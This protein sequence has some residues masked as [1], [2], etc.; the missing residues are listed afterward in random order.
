MTRGFQTV[1]TSHSGRCGFTL[2][3]IL[4]VIII[5]A[6]LAAVALPI[7]QGY[8][9][10]SQA[11]EL[12]LKY[13]AIR[14]NIQVAA[15]TGEVQAACANLSDTVQA[16][17]LRSDHAL[18]A[19][20]FEPVAGGFTP[21]LTMCATQAVQGGHGVEVVREAHHI[22]SRNSTISQ[23]AVI[24]ASAVSFSV[25]LAG[26]SALCKA[27]PPGGA[28][29]AGCNPGSGGGG[30]NGNPNK[31][32][33]PASGAAS[34]PITPASGGASSPAATL[35]VVPIQPVTIST[36]ATGSGAVAQAGTAGQNVCPAVTPGQVSRQAMSFASTANGRVSSVGNLNTRGNLP[37]V[38]A[39]VVIA[40]RSANAPGATLLSYTTSRPGSGFSLWNPQ[41]L[42]ITLAG[43]DYNTGFNAD[44]GQDHRITMSWHGASGLLTLFDNGRQVWQ[45]AGVNKF[46]NLG[47]NGQLTIGQDQRPV[48]G[49]LFNFRAGYSGTIVA[50]SLANRAA[51]AAMVSSGPLANVFPAGN[52][53]LTNVVMGSNG[54]PVDTTGH[55]SYRAA[56]GVS[57]ANAMVDTGVYVDSNCQ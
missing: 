37:S 3:E 53:L 15:K 25:R 6:L 35:V 39:E 46:G 30:Q 45:Q 27:L 5:I 17:N 10:R 50:A 33:T 41:S 21:V 2:L 7:Y 32:L 28:A 1:R 52:G 44:D 57:A 47:S 24:G 20:N 49:G 48:S 26:D 16:A 9:A 55:S 38:T 13:D 40:G 23:G 18:L 4:F 29:A 51:T 56:G 34:K 36:L 42:H 54:Q 43:T 12:A 31:P 11:A 14:T 22:L 8:A 19:V